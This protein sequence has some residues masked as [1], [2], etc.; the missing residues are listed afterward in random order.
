L[1]TWAAEKRNGNATTAEFVATAERVGGRQLDDL[2]AAW[3][4]GTER[5]AP[6]TRR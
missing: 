1:K 6:P 2:F 4:Y 3:L 5:P